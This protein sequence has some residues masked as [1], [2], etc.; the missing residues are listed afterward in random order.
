MNRIERHRYFL[1]FALSSLLRRRWKN[2]FL[3]FCYAL[4]IFLVSSVV[5]FSN[6]LR[7]ESTRLLEG[8]PELVVQRMM[9]GRHDLMP[10]DYSDAVRK[11]RGV[12]EAVPRLWGYYFHPASGATYTLMVPDKEK[13]EDG[14]ARVGS[15]VSRTWQMGKDDDMVFKTAAGGILP[16]TVADRFPS[17]SALAAADLILLN[18]ADFRRITGLPDGMATDLA[19]FVRNPAESGTI[20]EKVVRMLPDTRAVLREEIQRTY[21]TIFDWRSGY[22]LVIYSA[23]ILAFLIFTLDKATGL[24]AEEKGEIAVLKAI[25]WD[26][27]DVLLLKFWEGAAVSMTAF[28]VGVVAAYLH[29][30]HASAPLFEH[31]LKGW[32]TLY[33]ELILPPTV[34]A[35]QMA[36]IFAFTVVP[37]TLITIVPSWHTAVTDPDTVMRNA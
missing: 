32:S 17:E 4:I 23:A 16:V 33:P 27:S 24:S 9:A 3:L 30:F 13:P 18:E 10:V 7:E 5:F 36:V 31:A 2:F 34:S 25:G 20:A 12:E 11:I 15:E 35:Y 1:D 8:A 22:V 26:T 29:V 28:L 21:A 14:Q 6:A 19:V 37:Y